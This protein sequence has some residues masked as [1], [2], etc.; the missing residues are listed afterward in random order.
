MSTAG[1]WILEGEKLGGKFLKARERER[2]EL[3]NITCVANRAVL[4]CGDV[5]LEIHP[6]HL[7]QPE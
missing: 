6:A 1:S 5:F 7:L 3:V 4:V 2:E